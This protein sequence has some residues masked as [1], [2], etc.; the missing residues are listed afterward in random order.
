MRYRPETVSIE[1]MFAVVGF[2]LLAVLA[3][4]IWANFDL[5]PPAFLEFLAEARLP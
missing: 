1:A 3:A 2:L 5:V 4:V